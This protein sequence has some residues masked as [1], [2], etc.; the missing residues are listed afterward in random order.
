MPTSAGLAG[1]Q[2]TSHEFSVFA[3]RETAIKRH[4]TTTAA[5][6]IVLWVVAVIV[7][8][9]WELAQ[10]GLLAVTVE[11]GVPWLHCFVAS[12][13]DGLLVWVIYACGRVVFRREDWFEHPRSAQYAVTLT[14]GGLIGGLIGMIVEWVAAHLAHRWSYANAMPLVPTLNIGVV[15]ILRMLMRPPPI[16]RVVAA[17]N[18]RLAR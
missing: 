17:W 9:P 3:I 2:A 11:R 12:L 1:A 10:R 7:N 6:F 18:H 15:P 14:I 8:Y 13:G 16:F 4:G 5:R